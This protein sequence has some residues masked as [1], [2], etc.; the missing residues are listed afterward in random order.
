MNFCRLNRPQPDNRM[1][2]ETSGRVDEACIAVLNDH[3]DVRNIRQRET[4][5]IHPSFSTIF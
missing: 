3:Y 4:I 5:S 1:F 2:G